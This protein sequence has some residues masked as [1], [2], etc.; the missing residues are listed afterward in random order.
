MFVC[1]FVAS[2]WATMLSLEALGHILKTAREHRT[3]CWIYHVVFDV[4]NNL[5]YSR[6][7]DSLHSWC[8]LFF[9]L[10]NALPF[11]LGKR[12]N[13]ALTTLTKIVKV[14]DQTKNLTLQF[15]S[16]IILVYSISWCDV[17]CFLL[18]LLLVLYGGTWCIICKL[19]WKPKVYP[20]FP[21]RGCHDVVEA[22]LRSIWDTHTHTHWHLSW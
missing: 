19:R 22:F 20:L 4:N 1:F 6:S 16:K 18:L 3:L 17:F 11:N 7:S 21:W 2:T 14:A 10:V 12:E 9:Y 13:F 5:E 15:A 8:M